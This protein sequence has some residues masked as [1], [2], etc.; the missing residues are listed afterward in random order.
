[1]LFLAGFALVATAVFIFSPFISFSLSV[2]AQLDQCDR[3]FG[4]A[5]KLRILR[6]HL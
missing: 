6:V 3:F 2:N 5:R 4:C 1:L